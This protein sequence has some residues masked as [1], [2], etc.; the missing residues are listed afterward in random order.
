MGRLDTAR[1]SRRFL[2]SP[3]GRAA[4]RPGGDLLRRTSIPPGRFRT[5]P[6][7]CSSSPSA[8][9]PTAFPRRS[10]RVTPIP[11][12]SIRFGLREGNPTAAESQAFLVPAIDPVPPGPG[13]SGGRED[14]QPI[15][16]LVVALNVPG[17]D[18]A[19]LADVPY[20][21]HTQT[22]ATGRLVLANEHEPR[23]AE[24]AGWVSR[25][26]W[27]GRY[28]VLG[29]GLVVGSRCRQWFAR[30]PWSEVGRGSFRAAPA[31]A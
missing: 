9:R 12:M 8:L 7:R 19:M 23:P 27:L 14:T 21:A 4:T 6:V 16:S 18:G 1:A 5:S 20:P 31:D 24:D 30:E 3:A 10:S 29:H 11:D 22:W 25:G 15:P 2:L 17:C 26:V 13:S 28:E